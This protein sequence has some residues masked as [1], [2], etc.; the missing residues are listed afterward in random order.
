MCLKS[1]MAEKRGPYKDCPLV[2][3]L[4]ACVYMHSHGHGR[5]HT[6]AHTDHDTWALGEAGQ[7]NLAEDNGGNGAS[8]RVGVL[9]NMLTHNRT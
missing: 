9:A 7:D 8:A 1:S 6:H 4:H 3:P 5:M 2:K